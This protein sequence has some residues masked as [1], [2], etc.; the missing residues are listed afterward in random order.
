MKIHDPNEGGLEMIETNIYVHSRCECE[1][2]PL[3]E[4]GCKNSV[5][6]FVTNDLIMKIRKIQ[7]KDSA[8]EA[9]E[10]IYHEFSRCESLF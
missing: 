1:K 2:D 8:A 5:N 4:F 10:L 7:K 3:Y 9:H 6:W